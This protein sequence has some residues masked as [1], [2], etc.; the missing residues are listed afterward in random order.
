MTDAERA[1][2]N[3]YAARRAFVAPDVKVAFNDH[4]WNALAEAEDGLVKIAKS[5]K[6]PSVAE[7]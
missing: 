3:W 5:L 6:P 2:V 7:T 4:I 1:I